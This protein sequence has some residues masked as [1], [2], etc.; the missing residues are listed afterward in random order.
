VSEA[1]SPGPDGQPE[2]V[3][4]L[5]VF[6]EPHRDGC[7][8]CR[9]DETIVLRYDQIIRV[10]AAGVPF[11]AP[12]FVLLFK[13]RGYRQKDR[14]DFDGVLPLLAPGERAWLAAALRR[15]YPGHD[16]LASL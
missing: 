14:A 2:R 12:Q 8:V 5:D 10:D 7:W 13:A 3:Y 6:R 1:G 9:H 16:W 4:R 15:L 11:L